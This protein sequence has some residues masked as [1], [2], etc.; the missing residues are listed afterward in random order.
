M[1]F[2]KG[3]GL[4][5]PHDQPAKTFTKNIIDFIAFCMVFL[6]NDAGLVVLVAVVAIQAILM[7]F[8][9]LK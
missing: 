7:A 6:S 2:A 1:A 3:N 5:A 8:E 9:V 4:D